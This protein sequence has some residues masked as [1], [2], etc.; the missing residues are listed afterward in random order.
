MLS[1][2]LT[3]SETRRTDWLNHYFSF[4]FKSPAGMTHDS[5]SVQWVL[6]CSGSLNR[7]ARLR[8]SGIISSDQ[9][10]INHP[11]LTHPHRS[12]PSTWPYMLNRPLSQPVARLDGEEGRDDKDVNVRD[13]IKGSEADLTWS[14]NGEDGSDGR[15]KTSGNVWPTHLWTLETGSLDMSGGLAQKH[16]C[17]CN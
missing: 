15:E 2:L 12:S 4:L 11:A 16:G 8:T 14:R 10:D 7:Q 17:L 13:M 9:P 1:V 3:R 6:L 5:M